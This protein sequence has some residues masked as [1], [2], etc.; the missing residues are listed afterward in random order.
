MLHAI[1]WMLMAFLLALWSVAAWTLHALVRWTGDRSD[2]LTDLP[3]QLALWR[4][5]DWLALWLPQSAEAMWT[6]ML[7]ALTPMLEPLP[8]LAP[9]LEAWLSPM[10]WVLWAVGGLLILLFGSA[11]TLLISAGQRRLT[12]PAIRLAP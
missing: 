5:P 3:A 11:I 1:T 6:S 8:G 12:T 7:T 2:G 10:V 4:S 9:G